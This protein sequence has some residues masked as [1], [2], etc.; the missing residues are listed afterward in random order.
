MASKVVFVTLA[1]SVLVA[2][3]SAETCKQAEQKVPQDAMKPVASLDKV[4]L[5]AVFAQPDPV[6]T[7][8]E[9]QLGKFFDKKGGLVAHGQVTREAVKTDK[10]FKEVFGFE[11]RD[12]KTVAEET[13]R[14]MLDD[15]LV[16]PCQ[17]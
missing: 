7:D 15:H 11:A 16:T 17:K 12:E 14:A 2:C 9:E 5:D 1:V 6:D 3:V 4:Y 13:A 8:Y 10:R